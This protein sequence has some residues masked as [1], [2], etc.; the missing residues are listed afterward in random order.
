VAGCEHRRENTSSALCFN[1]IRVTACNKT[2]STNHR[3]LHADGFANVCCDGTLSSER[4]W[5]PTRGRVGRLRCRA[6][7]L[8]TFVQCRNELVSLT[9]RRRNA[10]VLARAC[11]R[12]A[13]LRK[14]AANTIECT[15]RVVSIAKPTQPCLPT[16]R[17]KRVAKPRRAELGHDFGRSARC[18]RKC[19]S[20]TAS[21]SH[22]KRLRHAHSPLPG[23]APS[24]PLYLGA[25]A[26]S[27][28]PLRIRWPTCHPPHA[29]SR[30]TTQL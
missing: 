25:C 23:P 13:N 9:S 29:L 2:A 15:E 11:I 21:G 20:E 12:P 14:C 27:A 18:A 24:V 7:I 10:R 4:M 30:S 5:G 6:S 26:S 28:R 3:V 19:Q 8:R 16:H 1:H 22:A 17:G